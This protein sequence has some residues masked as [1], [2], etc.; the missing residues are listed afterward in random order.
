VPQTEKQKF[1]R[2]FGKFFDNIILILYFP[3]LESLMKMREKKFMR[4]D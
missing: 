3:I 2:N 1:K 4:E